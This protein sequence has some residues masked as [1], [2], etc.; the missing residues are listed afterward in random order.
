MDLRE[1]TKLKFILVDKKP[2]LMAH[3]KINS[4]ATPDEARNRSEC[5]WITL[6]EPEMYW[7]SAGTV[8]WARPETFS[9][10]EE[11]LGVYK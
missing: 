2:V 11:F 1:C 6:Q 4:S 7:V 9:S 5:G 3:V 8:D 10:I